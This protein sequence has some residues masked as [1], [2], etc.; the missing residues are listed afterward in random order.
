MARGAEGA[1]AHARREAPELG[2]Q[3]FAGRDA[4]GRSERLA[5]LIT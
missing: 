3:P 1:H 2:D 5:R 4:V